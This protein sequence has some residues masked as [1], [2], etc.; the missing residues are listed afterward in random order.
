[1]QPARDPSQA[2]VHLHDVA[3]A[4]SAMCKLA[5]EFSNAE[6]VAADNE[7]LGLT[8]EDFCERLLPPK[9][10]AAHADDDE[11]DAKRG[12]KRWFKHMATHAGSREWYTFT[13]NE[14]FLYTLSAVT[15]KLN[16]DVLDLFDRPHHKQTGR[17][18]EFEFA[19]LITWL[20]FGSLTTPLFLEHGGHGAHNEAGTAARPEVELES[21]RRSVRAFEKRR[22]EEEEEAVLQMAE[23]HRTYR[24]SRPVD[25]STWVLYERGCAPGADRQGLAQL[26]RRLGQLVSE[27]GRRPVDLFR[28][29]SLNGD[30]LTQRELELT[31]GEYGLNDDEEASPSDKLPSDEGPSAAKLARALAS[32][33]SDS[34]ASQIGF[35]AF[36]SWLHGFVPAGLADVTLPADELVGEWDEARLRSA[37]R[38]L[39]KA[40]G[41]RP[42][43]LLRAWATGEARL[44]E[45]QTSPTNEL[46]D[47][48]SPLG[49][50]MSTPPRVST[51]RVSVSGMERSGVGHVLAAMQQ[52]GCDRISKRE[53]LRGMKKLVAT[54]DDEL[55]FS[56]IRPAIEDA[57]AKLSRLSVHHGGEPAIEFGPLDEWAGRG[58]DAPPPASEAHGAQ[59]ARGAAAPGSLGRPRSAV[60]D[61][62]GVQPWRPSGRL[63][64]GTPTRSDPRPRPPSAVAVA[65]ALPRTRGQ[66]ARPPP[67]RMGGGGGGRAVTTLVAALPRQPA[68]PDS[69]GGTVAWRHA[70]E[71]RDLPRLIA[72]EA[73]PASPAS[74][75]EAP[76]RVYISRKLNW[77][78]AGMA[79]SSIWVP[80][81]TRSPKPAPALPSRR[82]GLVGVSFA[83]PGAAARPATAR[84]SVGHMKRGARPGAGART[85]R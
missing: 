14:F 71:L 33:L 43:Q 1:M 36:R 56:E 73:R 13:L 24:V 40:H 72:A 26:G 34:S 59:P 19:E 50:R 16:I 48:S 32:R 74:N 81:A 53:F 15:T 54:E 4:A 79:I 17:L 60:T 68:L 57:F 27:A 82:V 61:A 63:I 51:T 11:D 41:F 21:F 3:A 38:R 44:A 70:C 75:E 35:E 65:T 25:D 69:S 45:P 22:S 78:P 49:P 85:A 47:N 10:V 28:Q 5:I 55:W 6:H 80:S 77:P 9:V 7:H 2:R 58:V 84:P 37:T 62:Q 20:G 64:G 8:Y 30:F 18:N 42:I 67:R 29:L 76:P 83:T 12:P 52:R 46:R 39:L 66:Q 31:L 23:A